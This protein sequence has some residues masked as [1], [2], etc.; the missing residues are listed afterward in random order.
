MLNKTA[1]DT[2]CVLYFYWPF[3]IKPSAYQ[4]NDLLYFNLYIICEVMCMSNC[5]CSCVAWSARQF[6]E[7]NK[8]LFDDDDDVQP[9]I[10]AL[11]FITNRDEIE[12]SK[13]IREFRYVL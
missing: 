2:I 3:N 11:Q 6:Y 5:L 7:T 1:G 9:V 8:A 13:S 10:L 12:T 4:L